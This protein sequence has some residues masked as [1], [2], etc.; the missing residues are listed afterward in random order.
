MSLPVFPD[1]S[2]DDDPDKHF[3]DA[4]D[5]EKGEEKKESQRKFQMFLSLLK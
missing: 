5:S 3:Y 1:D 4:C 2:I